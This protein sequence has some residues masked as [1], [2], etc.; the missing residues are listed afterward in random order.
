MQK[1]TLSSILEEVLHYAFM[2]LSKRTSRIFILF[3]FILLMLFCRSFYGGL[4]GFKGNTKRRI[5]MDTESDIYIPR[6]NENSNIVSIKS[7]TRSNVCSA[8]RKIR[9]VIKSLRNR[10]KPT[11]FL[12]VPFNNGEVQ[13]G[14]VEL[15]VRQL[16]SSLT[17]P[18]NRCPFLTE[19]HS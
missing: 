17:S 8:L 3:L 7:K 9:A 18:G 6:Q 2:C 11:H 5:E 1:T 4:I 19:T 10:M 13:Q 16:V 15:K 14:F 12:A